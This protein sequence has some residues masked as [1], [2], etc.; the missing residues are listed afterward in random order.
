VERS[1]LEPM[2]TL[3]LE[4]GW[5][6]RR[7]HSARKHRQARRRTGFPPCPARRGFPT[8]VSTRPQKIT[9]TGNG[10]C[11][12][13]RKCN[14]PNGGDDLPRPRPVIRRP[15]NF[16]VPSRGR[17]GRT[18]SSQP[19][20]I[21]H[22]PSS[23]VALTAPRVTGRTVAKPKPDPLTGFVNMASPRKTPLTRLLQSSTGIATRAVSPTAPCRES[24]NQSSARNRCSAAFRRA[25]GRALGIH[26]RPAPLIFH[27]RDPRLF[28][29]SPRG[30]A[31]GAECIGHR[32]TLARVR[33]WV[34]T[35]ALA[36]DETHLRTS[37]W[38]RRAR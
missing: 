15:Q 1:P 23:D 5:I 25:T 16:L 12:T 7:G 14:E 30:R 8:S 33:R 6:G 2:I 38:P 21:F 24:C 20:L 32:V 35:S 29:Y 36:F 26:H 28:G 17:N 19:S 4:R 34:I 22:N 18:M 3:L 9:S 31:L 37:L 10:F 13:S 11:R 27:K